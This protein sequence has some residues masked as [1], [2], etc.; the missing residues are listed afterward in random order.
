VKSLAMVVLIVALASSALPNVAQNPASPGQLSGVFRA[1][2][3]GD[4]AGVG[5]SFFL[6]FFPDGHVM[7]G[8]P[9]GGLAGYNAAYQM[10]LDIRTGIPAR[11]WR[12]G[13]Y[14]VSGQQGNL[15]FA[16]RDSVAI[17]LK[18][19]PRTVEAVGLTY[20]LL[21]PGDGLGL[22]GT[23]RSTKDNSTISF[24]PGS[25]M[26][27]QG[28]VANCVSGGQHFSY[29]GS[30]PSMSSASQLCLDK[31][32]AGAYR[33]GSYTIQFVFPDSTKPTFSFWA[34][35]TQ[36]RVNPP[37]IYISGVKFVSAN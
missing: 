33:I 17:D 12:W 25:M 13:V 28:I 35:L 7:R 1:Q 16:N 15:D 11:V 8:A 34:D 36:N 10:S 3:P 14:R 29:G 23:Y 31:P 9:E 37:A 20:M 21:D 27:Q 2:M 22:Q 30:I 32:K 18:G 26:N 24:L 6:A 19:Y 5:P 4:A